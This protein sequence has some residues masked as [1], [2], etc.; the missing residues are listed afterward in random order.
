[1]AV[2]TLA[3]HLM[4]YPLVEVGYLY[5]CAQIGLGQGDL[6]QIEVVGNIAPTD[7]ARPFAPHPQHQQQRRWQH[8]QA[9][10]LLPV[11]AALPA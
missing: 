5:Y 8:P 2:D 3:A 9:G 6:N 1:L 10:V 11:S 7:V 4:G